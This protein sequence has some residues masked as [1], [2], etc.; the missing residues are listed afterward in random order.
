METCGRILQCAG[1]VADTATCCAT[2]ERQ[3]PR[4]GVASPALIR[5]AGCMQSSAVPG[6]LQITQT[7]NTRFDAFLYWY[8][9]RRA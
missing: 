7:R 1:I 5:A 2:L 4:L 8:P 9:R 3:D 6:S